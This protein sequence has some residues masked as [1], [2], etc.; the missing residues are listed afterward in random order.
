M[1]SRQLRE[2]RRTALPCGSVS[3]FIVI[4]LVSRLSL[5]NHSWWCSHRSA[6]MDSNQKDSGRLV[7]RMDWSLLCLFDLS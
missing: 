2:P 3:G 5:V 7:G 1:E 4:G 6:K